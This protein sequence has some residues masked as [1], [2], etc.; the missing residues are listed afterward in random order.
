V[1]DVVG[2]STLCPTHFTPG[3]ETWYLFYRRLGRPLSQPGQV[4]KILPPLGFY[5]QIVHSIVSH[6]IN[7]TE[8]TGVATF[9]RGPE[10]MFV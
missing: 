1:I 2:L 4:R 6:Y 10:G 3:K 9:Y 8:L 7:Y 5:P